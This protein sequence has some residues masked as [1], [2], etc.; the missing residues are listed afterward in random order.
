MPSGYRSIESRQ[1][2]DASLGISPPSSPQYSVP[3][4]KVSAHNTRAAKEKI[5]FA[6]LETAIGMYVSTKDK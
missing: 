4:S 5:H 3:Q 6:R 1:K 2:T